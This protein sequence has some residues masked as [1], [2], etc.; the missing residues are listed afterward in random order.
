MVNLIRC[1]GYKLRKSKIVWFLFLAMLVLSVAT[2]QSSLSFVGSPQAQDLGM[3]F[4]GY[5]VFFVS[6]RDTP[7]LIII[8]VI[9]IGLIICGDFDN[10]TIQAEIAAG[11]HRGLILMSKYLALGISYAIVLLPYPLGRAVIQGLQYNFARE[12]TLATLRDMLLFYLTV[13]LVS[14]SLLSVCILLAFL[15][16]RTVLAMGLGVILLVFGGNLLLSFGVSNPK[17]GSF[18]AQT[19]VGAGRALAAAGL[20]YRMMAQA[21]GV[22]LVFMALFACITY[23]VFRKAELK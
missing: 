13:I 21:A 15:L 14:L 1:E 20:D 2:S 10:R 16:R 9:M 6:L 18:L 3:V 11:H 23:F 17:F 7:T 8:G 19:P 4:D 12:L 5:E 22:S